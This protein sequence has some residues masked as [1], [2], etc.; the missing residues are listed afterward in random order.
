MALK[1]PH[2]DLTLIECYEVAEVGRS[3]DLLGLL[4]WAARS[5]RLTDRW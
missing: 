1:G 2:T 4:R 5:Q 3:W